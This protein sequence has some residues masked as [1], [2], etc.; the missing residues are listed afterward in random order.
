MKEMLSILVFFTNTEYLLSPFGIPKKA[1]I[2]LLRSCSKYRIL[3][4]LKNFKKFK[5]DMNFIIINF[6]IQK[7][8]QV[9]DALWANNKQRLSR[10]IKCLFVFVFEP[11]GFKYIKDHLRFRV[12]PSLKLHL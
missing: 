8:H 4:N 10:D 3:T 6:Q 2:A 9:S 5:V 11:S 12:F 1:N 7:E